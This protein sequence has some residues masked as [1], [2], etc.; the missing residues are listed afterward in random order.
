MGRLLR[1][2]RTSD[3]TTV[4][5]FGSLTFVVSMASQLL[6]M[7]LAAAL[8]P[9]SPLVTGLVDDAFRTALLAT[10]VTLLPRPGVVALALVLGQV[11]RGLGLGSFHPLDLVT[12]GSSIAFLETS[13]WATGLTRGGAW[14][15]QA[16]WTRWVRMSLGFGIPSALSML[17]AL[18]VGTVF[19]RMF[20]A[21][22]YVLLMVALPGFL[23]VVGACG[24]AVRFAA[25]LRRVE[26]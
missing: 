15:D 10:L 6:G 18:S 13:L 11:M 8:G 26:A 5:V 1:G 7:A 19:Y 4:A 16:P 25:S 9:F 12:L 22:W 17:C 3:L 23:Y 21:P 2:A 20:Y 24:I 14:R